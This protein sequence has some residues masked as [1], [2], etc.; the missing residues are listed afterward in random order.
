[1]TTRRSFLASILAAG[2]APAAVGSGILMPVKTIVRLPVREF[3][4]V[5]WINGAYREM[6]HRNPFPE[7]GWIT[8]GSAWHR[9]EFKDGLFIVTSQIRTDVYVSA[10]A[11]D[12]RDA[13]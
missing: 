6:V 3:D 10:N 13:L 4:L 2:M 8:D 11:L 9:V 1:M 5:E 12:W 7:N